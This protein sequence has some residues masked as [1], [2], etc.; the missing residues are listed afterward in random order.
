[1]RY[2][3]NDRYYTTDFHIILFNT[4][5]AFPVYVN[6]YEFTASF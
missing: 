3:L 5:K 1:M 2:H 6:E 4:G